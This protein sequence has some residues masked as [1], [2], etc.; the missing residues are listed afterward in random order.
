MLPD[1]ARLPWPGSTV[2]VAPQCRCLEQAAVGLRD[3]R[4]RGTLGV[5]AADS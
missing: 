2:A 4:G 1:Q 5:A 3:G